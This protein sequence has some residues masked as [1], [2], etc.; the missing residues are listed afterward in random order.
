MNFGDAALRSILFDL[1]F[2]IIVSLIVLNIV[3]A[4]IVDTF[5]EL[6]NKKVMKLLANYCG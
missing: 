3:L 6:R 1:T 5:A 4:I 2:F